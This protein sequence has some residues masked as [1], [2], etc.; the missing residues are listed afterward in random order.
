MPYI[1]T[2]LLLVLPGML[3]AR[4]HSKLRGRPS[5]A[6]RLVVYLSY[7]AIID[8]VLLASRLLRGASAET[9]FSWFAPPL[10]FTF[11]LAA[12][13]VMAVVLPLLF[14][15][16]AEKR[17][18]VHRFPGVQ[19]QP[20]EKWKLKRLWHVL[21]RM[22]AVLVAG[23]LIGA[24]LVTAVYALPLDNIQENVRESAAVI[25]EEGSYPFL[26][27]NWR[28]TRLDNFTD[29]I[30]L[31]MAAY[32]G[33]QGLIGNAMLSTYTRYADHNPAEGLVKWSTG[34][35]TGIQTHDYSRYWHGYLLW[36]KPLLEIMNY[37]QIRIL[38]TVLQ[39]LLVLAAGLVMVLKK[40][41]RLVLPF[42][43]LYLFL[44]PLAL[45]KS[46]QFSWVFYVCIVSS[47]ALMLRFDT[48]K[49]RRTFYLLFMITGM[50]TSYVDFL[51]Y[52][53]ITLGVPL[54]IYL[55][56]QPGRAWKQ[57]ILDVIAFALVWGVGYVGMWAG[58]WVLCT[59]LTDNNV[60]QSVGGNISSRMSFIY[61]EAL[62]DNVEED[63]T[64]LTIFQRN[65][66]AFNHWIYM[67]PFLLALFA[68]AHYYGKERACLHNR[69]LLVNVNWLTGAA[70]PLLLVALSPVAWFFVAS[71]HTYIHYWFTHRTLAITVFA[72]LAAFAQPL[73]RL[74]KTR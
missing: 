47:L 68:Y 29:S 72:V 12:A 51:T 66:E 30:M 36:L 67:A 24:V 64:V 19:Y 39:I 48:L 14:V 4:L 61:V 40:Q 2:V 60:L 18:A 5:G 3:A 58:K 6:M 63:F 10:S 20:Q 53:L 43:I 57:G 26:Y 41:K 56:M 65:L 69:S 74:A 11:Y 21:P 28:S 1:V 46:L 49:R 16:T 15:L 73:P 25:E 35:Q 17:L 62:L 54:V 27:S 50:A 42:L 33:D 70:L 59:L 31:L 38:N 13:L 8:G 71:N 37:Q 44:T 7:T 52:P 45:F 34:D 9:F 23:I 22:A 32:D 55:V